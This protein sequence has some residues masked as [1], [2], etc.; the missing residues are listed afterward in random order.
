M[1][2]DTEDQKLKIL[3]PF[4]FTKEKSAL[5]Y[6]TNLNRYQLLTHLAEF[7]ELGT[8]AFPEDETGRV[9]DLDAVR[10]RNIGGAKERTL[11]PPWYAM[12]GYDGIL[13]LSQFLTDDLLYYR[14]PDVPIVHCIDGTQ[15]IPQHVL[16]KVLL[17][18]RAFQSRKDTLVVKASW[19]RD[20]LVS[21]LGMSAEN[22]RVI[23]DGIDGVAPIGDKILAKQ[24]TAAIFEK[25]MF[26]QQPVVGLISGF[27]PSR[28]AAWISE[29]A[30]A[31]PHLAIFVYDT[32]LEQQYRQP[33]E[34]V[35]IFS[36]DDEETRSV[37]PIFFQAVDLV[38]FPAM[39]GTPL[40]V[41]LA[42]MA[43]ETPCVAMTKYGMPPEV[44][45]A[46][47]AVKADW[48]PAGDFHVS[49]AAVSSAVYEGLHLSE[50]RG[51]GSTHFTER[52]VQQYTRK[53][54][55]QALVRVFAESLHRK[56]DDVRTESTLFPPIFCRRYEPDT[57]T[58]RS[59]VYRLGTNRYDRLAPAVAERLA[60]RHTPAEVASVFKHFQ[61]ARATSACETPHA[62]TLPV[63]RKG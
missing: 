51:S 27:E 24:H 38:C 53:A 28:G 10:V 3:V 62:E 52:L 47:V 43:Y 56:M 61:Q 19:M 23:P 20:W 59:C 40:S 21:E 9:P 26:A 17:T 63:S 45:G 31:H 57:G 7:A 60:K 39:P 8:L 2:P 50:A 15:R 18:L 34:N 4:H 36:A 48:D 6:L 54:A 22:V 42:A 12:D 32:L 11:M 14:V 46:G 33:P 29:F 13:L 25:P 49:M 58:L 55:A 1:V 16:L 5:D 30:R 41:V 44:A 37:L 35:I